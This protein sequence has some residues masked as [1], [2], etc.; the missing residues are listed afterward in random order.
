MG[1][2][3]SGL[4]IEPDCRGAV[5]DKGVRWS[6]SIFAVEPSLELLT[7]VLASAFDADS[8]VQHSCSTGGR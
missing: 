4:L 1:A 7:E 3:L 2:G 8:Q 6:R 5:A